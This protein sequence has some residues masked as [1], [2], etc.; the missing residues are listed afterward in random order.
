[1]SNLTPSRT[2]FICVVPAVIALLSV[3]WI[4]KK[5]KF[6]HSDA[7]PQTATALDNEK[8]DSLAAVCSLDSSCLDSADTLSDAS[9]FASPES[10]YEKSPR[11]KNFTTDDVVRTENFPIE[12]DVVVKNSIFC[13]SSSPVAPQPNSVKISPMP[14]RDFQTV[15]GSK[16]A[17]SDGTLPDVVLRDG[18]DKS[19]KCNLLSSLKLEEVPEFDISRHSLSKEE[20]SASDLF[21][22]LM[23]APNFNSDS[24][25]A[26][27]ALEEMLGFSPSSLRIVENGMSHS[28]DSSDNVAS[29]ARV[30]GESENL[31]TVEMDSNDSHSSVLDENSLSY[32]SDDSDRQAA[33]LKN[34]VSLLSDFDESLC[35]DMDKSCSPILLASKSLLAS[36]ADTDDKPVAEATADLDFT[37]APAIKTPAKDEPASVDQCADSANGP[38]R[39]PEARSSS[40]GSDSTDSP[41]EPD[42]SAEGQTGRAG[43]TPPVSCDSSALAN[44]LLAKSFSPLTSSFP[45]SVGPS[46]ETALKLVNGDGAV[47]DPQ[48]PD[49]DISERLSRKSAPSL[50]GT[51]NENCSESS[52]WEMQDSQYDVSTLHVILWL[53]SFSRCYKINSGLPNIIYK[54]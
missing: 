46:P 23:K 37:Q 1:M 47:E 44:V 10:S 29:P 14:S 4:R 17:D 27:E 35:D 54:S 26:M 7:D 11:T 33:G 24:M 43:E 36:I 45:A 5:K 19:V 25:N 13:N 6:K 42:S 12:A 31:Q 8:V 40:L 30:T 18:A 21:S 2:L 41:P 20:E 28:N 32:V 53:F 16:A 34:K 39:L 15:N 38:V 9:S 49:M 51:E 22:M 3:Y 52:G 48:I 50:T